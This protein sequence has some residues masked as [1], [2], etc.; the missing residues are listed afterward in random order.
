MAQF[1]LQHKNNTLRR[2]YWQ[3]QNQEKLDWMKSASS[4]SSRP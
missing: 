3:Y 2:L 1:L 4:N